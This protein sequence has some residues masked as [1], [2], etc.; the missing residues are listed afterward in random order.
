[1]QLIRVIDLRG[2]VHHINPNHIVRIEDFETNIIIHLSDEFELNTKMTMREL[3]AS[4]G[5]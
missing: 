2:D 5:A 3:K 1:M 4:L